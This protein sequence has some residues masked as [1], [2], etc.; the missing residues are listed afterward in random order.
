MSSFDAELSH[1][2]DLSG[3]ALNTRKR[4]R[5]SEAIV[6]DSFGEKIM[7]IVEEGVNDFV[8]I[9]DD[10]DSDD[11][12][13]TTEKKCRPSTTPKKRLNNSM[14]V[15]STSDDM[16]NDIVHVSQFTTPLSTSD[17]PREMLKSSKVV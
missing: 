1:S 9:E 7:N 16:D 11:F 5:R 17:S 2:Q 4:S 10:Q 12:S 15:Q 8:L 13:V 6:S 14:T 3:P